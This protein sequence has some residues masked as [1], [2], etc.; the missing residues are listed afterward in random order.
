[1]ADQKFY[2]VF[3]KDLGY[4]IVNTDT[5]Y[6]DKEKKISRHNY[7]MVGKSYS[8]GGEIIFGPKYKS[9]MKEQVPMKDII[10]STTTNVGEVLIFK[11]N[12]QTAKSRTST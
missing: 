5:P 11:K 8:K 9:M 6:W 4:F 12:Y 1:M 10:V 2:Y 3:R 7:T